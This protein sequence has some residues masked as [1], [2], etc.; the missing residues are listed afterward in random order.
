[1]NDTSTELVEA[2]NAAFIQTGDLS[3]TVAA[4][5]RKLSALMAPG[6]EEGTE[7]PDPDDLNL[8]ADDIWGDAS[9]GEPEVTHD[10]EESTGQVAR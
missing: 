10:P 1:M 5:L 2:A 6:W 8:L 3:A 7:W 4:V 9:S